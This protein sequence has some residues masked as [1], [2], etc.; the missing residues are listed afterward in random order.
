MRVVCSWC[1]AEKLPTGVWM[2]LA[3][4]EPDDMGISHGICPDCS[5]RMETDLDAAESDAD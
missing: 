4:V 2:D 1:G 5:E 3:P